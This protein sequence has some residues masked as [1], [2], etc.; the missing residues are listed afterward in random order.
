M[1]PGPASSQTRKLRAGCSPHCGNRNGYPNTFMHGATQRPGTLILGVR[2]RWALFWSGGRKTLQSISGRASSISNCRPCDGCPS[3]LDGGLR[4]NP[5]MASP[6]PHRS[7]LQAHER[8]QLSCCPQPRARELPIPG[9]KPA[10]HPSTENRCGT[11]L[12]ISDLH[13]CFTR[14]SAAHSS[15]LCDGFL[16]IK[17]FTNRKANF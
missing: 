1:G 12:C 15:E 7:F 6:N 5:R 11:G 17:V 10:L 2:T 9:A 3:S 4:V 16:V 14:K 13:P 8:R